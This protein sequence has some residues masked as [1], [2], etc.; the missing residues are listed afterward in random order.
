MNTYSS[1]AAIAGHLIAHPVRQLVAGALE[2]SPTRFEVV[3]PATGEPCADC[4]AATLDQL[5]RAV[6]AARCAQPGWASMGSS[7]RVRHLGRLADV[8]RQNE[9]E[10]AAIITLEQ[11]KPFARALDEARRAA[12]QI[13]RVC[14]LDTGPALLQ[15]DREGRIELHYRPLGVV[16]AITPWNMPLVLALPKISHALHTGNTIVLK[17]SPFTPLSILR[18]AA[19]AQ[20]VFP[21]GVLNIL[22]GGDE[23]GRAMSSHPGI[24]KISFTGSIETGKRVMQSAAGTLKRLTL[25]LGGNDPAIVLPDADLDAVLPRIFGAAFAN[26]GQVC[27]AIKRLYVHDSLYEEVA[28]R[29]A[30]IARNT[31]VGDGFD[32]ATDLGPVQ[33]A[34]QYAR[35]REL[36][37]DA[38]L[39]GGKFLSGDEAAQEQGSK[40]G[41][42]IQ[43][44]I[45]TGLPEDAR[46]VQE[47]PFGPVLPVLKYS[48]IEDVVKRANNT[49]FG[50][51]ASVWGTDHDAAAAIGARLEAGVVWVNK[52]MVLDACAP[53][54]GV[55][56]SGLGREYGVDG[57]R[58]YTDPVVM[59]LPPR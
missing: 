42:F 15:D 57:V 21:T 27:M 54:G 12:Y 13:G 6:A 50:L 25:E 48:D 41:Y 45:I 7:G 16:G 23:I 18:L 19:L 35:V 31:V 39:R 44:A 20:D 9:Q 24:A 8:L 51:G 36:L 33:N 58:E 43:P 32:P 10:L 55:K 4:P 59:Y 26:S 38:K 30:G 14:Q 56:E 11:G 29:L 22:A 28:Q 2:D 52:H 49:R 5:E 1:A 40:S 17:P 47:E 53:F 34:T 3:N 37:A 46:I